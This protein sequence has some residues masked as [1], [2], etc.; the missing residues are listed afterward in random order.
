MQIFEFKTSNELTVKPEAERAKL[1]CYYQYKE[2]G[3]MSFSMT[4]IADLIVSAGFNTPN[5][6]RLKDALT[7]G[8]A[9][10]FLVSKTNKGTLEF[11]PSVLQELD[12]SVG[13]AWVDTTEITS[14]SEMIDESKFCGQRHYL[15]RLVKQINSSYENHCYDACAVL[16]RRLFE[17]VLILSY[18]NLKVNDSIKSTDGRYFMLEAIVNNA[19]GNS[20]LNLP[21]RVRND[22]DIIREVGNLS[23]HGIT[24]T[25]GK[26]DVDDIKL[27]YRV[28]L[29][30]LYCK[31][32]LI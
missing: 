4:S 25:A 28:M 20:T 1:L 11:I 26:K 32:G 6:S 14:N 15:T 12:L 13:Q 29:E 19:K 10:A 18:E 17:V 31:A 22:L 24:Y 21:S 23:A 16:L 27:K 5:T 2:N 7:K 30:E 9:R 3:I 8:K